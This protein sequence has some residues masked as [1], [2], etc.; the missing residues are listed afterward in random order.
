MLRSYLCYD[1]CVRLHPIF[2][3]QVVAQQRRYILRGGDG[4]NGSR[5]TKNRTDFS[6]VD[7]GACKQ[8]L[9]RLVS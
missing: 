8:S 4:G 7:V 6:V 9:V 3:E 1:E 5:R 2:F